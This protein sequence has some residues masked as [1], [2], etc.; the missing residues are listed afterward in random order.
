MLSTGDLIGEG[1][2]L[3]GEVVRTVPITPLTAPSE[4]TSMEKAGA[5]DEPAK[6]FEVVR[7]LGTGSYAVVYLVREVLHLAAPLASPR[8]DTDDGRDLDMSLDG[9]SC[10]DHD[11]DERE[12]EGRSAGAVGQE[13]NGSVYGRE[14]A[15]KLLSKANLDDEALAAQM[16]EVR[17]RRGSFFA[18]EQLKL[19]I[20][21]SVGTDTSVASCTP[22]HCH[23]PQ[24][25]RYPAFP[26]PPAR[27]RPR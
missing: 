2:E 14:F 18:H 1:L 6:T 7:R 16:F 8:L 27:I 5:G 25:A 21:R 15:V 4:E 10:D 12:M 23:P 26:A 13:E 24:R 22:E 20:G 17:R 3:Q 9:H 19:N 11:D